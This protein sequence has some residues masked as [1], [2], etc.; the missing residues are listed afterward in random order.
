MRSVAAYP[1][2]LIHLAT[3]RSMLTLNGRTIKPADVEQTEDEWMHWHTICGIDVIGH[4]RDEY[5]DWQLCKRC[6][7]VIGKAREV[8]QDMERRFGG[9][10]ADDHGGQGAGQG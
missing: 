8:Y 1:S 9:E 6:V 5:E 10:Q 4:P 3:V 7:K 2:Y